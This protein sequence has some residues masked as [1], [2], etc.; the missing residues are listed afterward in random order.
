[1][2]VSRTLLRREFLCGLVA[3]GTVPVFVPAPG[4]AQRHG[5]PPLKSAAESRGLFWGAA[6]QHAQLDDDLEFAALVAQQCSVIVPEW[7]MKWA[8]I[9][10]HP[11]RPNFSRADAIVRYAQSLGLALR[12]HTLL[13]HRSIPD[14]AKDELSG[15]HGWDLVASHITGMMQRYGTAPFL[16]WDVLNE[17]IEPKDGRTDGLRQS[18]FLAA[19]GP[20]YLQRALKVARGAAPGMRLYMNEYGVDY[21]GSTERDRRSVLLRLVETLKNAEAPLDGVGIQGHLRLGDEHFSARS[22][23]EFLRTLANLG[24]RI[25]IT[26]LDV[27]ESDLSLPL[28]VRDARVADEVKRY[29]DVVLQEPALDG[30]VSWGLSDRYSWRTTAALEE[31]GLVNRGLP[32]DQALQPKPVTTAIVAA[33]ERRRPG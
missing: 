23:R 30:I 16:Q 9:E 17:V 32:F 26:E 1:M 19:F 12:G 8:A 20:D 15:P 28:L 10:R 29:L 13:W 7:E 22:L 31:K 24:V 3:V 6:I 18:P 27:R 14:W 11:N 2:I 33:L 21:D 5:V 4:L 25:T